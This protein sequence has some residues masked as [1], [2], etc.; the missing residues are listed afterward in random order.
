MQAG[1]DVWPFYLINAEIM[2]LELANIVIKEGQNEAFELALNSAKAVIAQSK[3]FKGIEIN[4]C[5]EESNRYAFFIYWESLEDH[6]IGFRGSEL[7]T[8]W[9]ALIGPYF[10]TPPVVLHYEIQ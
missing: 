1:Q 7:F 2:I 3:G 5:I 6:T 4:K 8:K 10:D 9:R